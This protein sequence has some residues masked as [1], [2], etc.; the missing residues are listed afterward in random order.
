MKEFILYIIGVLLVSC[1]NTVSSQEINGDVSSNFTIKVGENLTENHI[2]DAENGTHTIEYKASGKDSF[3]FNDYDLFHMHRAFLYGLPSYVPMPLMDVLGI[4]TPNE[5][6]FKKNPYKQ[7]DFSEFAYTSYRK[8]VRS[9]D[10]RDILFDSIPNLSKRIWNTPKSCKTRIIDKR[11]RTQNFPLHDFPATVRDKYDISQGLI[12]ETYVDSFF[13]YELVINVKSLDTM[14]YTSR[15]TE[16]LE[17]GR[18]KITKTYFNRTELHSA[19]L[20]NEKSNQYIIPPLIQE[21]IYDRNEVVSD[22]LYV[23]IGQVKYM[24]SGYEYNNGQEKRYCFNSSNRFFPHDTLYTIF[25]AHSDTILTYEYHQYQSRDTAP[26]ILALLD[27]TNEYFVSSKSTIKT[28]DSA[29]YRYKYATLNYGPWLPIPRFEMLR[30]RE[31]SNAVYKSSELLGVGKGLIRYTHYDKAGGFVSDIKSGKLKNDNSNTYRVPWIIINKYGDKSI[32]ED[33]GGSIGG[34]V[35]TKYIYGD[36]VILKLYPK[37]RWP[38]LK[39]IPTNKPT[40][41]DISKRTITPS[42]LYDQFSHVKSDTLHTQF[43]NKRITNRRDILNFDSGYTVSGVPHFRLIKLTERP[44]FSEYKVKIKADSL[45]KIDHDFV[46]HYNRFTTRITRDYYQEYSFQLDEDNQTS[47]ASELLP[48][49]PSYPIGIGVTTNNWQ[50][51]QS[52]KNSFEYKGTDVSPDNIFLSKDVNRIGIHLKH[53]TERWNGDTLFISEKNPKSEYKAVIIRGLINSIDYIKE[54]LT[55]HLVY[56][57]KTE[58]GIKLVNSYDSY[59]QE[60]KGLLTQ[61]NFRFSSLEAEDYK[62]QILQKHSLM[63]YLRPNLDVEQQ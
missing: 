18:V 5:V 40:S 43:F 55:Y 53:I 60:I 17:N 7:D 41:L 4:P 22:K 37:Y 33:V 12:R 36:S 49:V 30:P 31:I 61:D 51:H 54:G 10:G 63:H 62:C 59:P 8:I 52:S 50:G 28:D 21:S 9:L 48:Y 14:Y 27:T 16:D 45:Y 24:W 44:N 34:I 6:D 56:W 11:L 23:K 26:V 29:A 3:W 13:K 1:S 15:F 57:E 25:N 58:D 2:I 20:A 42:N 46:E 19:F 47:T 38:K 35:L 39:V 32:L